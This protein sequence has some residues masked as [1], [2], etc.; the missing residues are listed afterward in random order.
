MPAETLYIST[1]LLLLLLSL[2]TGAV[3]TI[4]LIIC[5][6]FARPHL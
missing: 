6:Y 1:N 5:L 3:T 2:W 4:L